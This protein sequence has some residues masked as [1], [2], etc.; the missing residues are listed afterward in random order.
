MRFN[1][2]NLRL[3]NIIIYGSSIMV[4]LMDILMFTLMNI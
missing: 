4:N 3:Y 1:D 2:L